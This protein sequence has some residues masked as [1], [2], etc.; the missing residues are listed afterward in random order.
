MIGSYM[1]TPIYTPDNC[2]PAYQL[3]WSLSLFSKVDLPSADDWFAHLQSVVEA[4]CIRLLEVKASSSKVCQFLLSTTPEVSPPAIVKSVKGRLQH[5]LRETHSKA[6]QRNLSLSSLGDASR[7]VT[8]AYVADQLGH[9]RMADERV[10]ELLARF[11][12]S[13]ANVNLSEA[14]FSAHGRH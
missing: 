14:T 12:L 11:Q 5:H 6:F 13:F 7:E 1:P 4:D 8:E 9:H 3:R 10:N 2:V